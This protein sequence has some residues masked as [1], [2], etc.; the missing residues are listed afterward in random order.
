VLFVA[1]AAT[2][3][4]VSRPLVLAQALDRDEYDVHFACTPAYHGLLADSSFTTWPLQSL[5]G[6]EF[7]RALA[8]GRRLF[9]LATLRRYV[10][11]DLKLIQAVQ[12]D[13]IV[14]D[15]RF[16][17][18]VS[19]ARQGVPH[20]MIANAYWSPFARQSFHVP[21]L[22]LT[23]VLGPR[24]GEAMFKL[25]RPLV[26]AHHNRPINQL[27]KEFGLPTLGWDHRRLYTDA[28]Q[29]LYADVPE[30]VPTYDLPEHHHYLG[31]ITWSFPTPLPDWWDTLAADRPL[32][33]VCLGSSGRIELLP[34]V[35]EALG[36]LPVTVMASTC[37]RAR[38]A[39]LPRNVHWAEYL[40]GEAASARA[41]LV[42][43]HGG[44]AAAYVALAAGKPV[45]GIPSNIDQHLTIDYIERA[46]AGRSV[47]AEWATSER[48]RAVVAAMLNDASL[49]AAAAHLGKVFASCD[50]PSRFR[51]LLG[52][53]LPAKPDPILSA[54]L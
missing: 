54:A 44:S 15:L 31:P 27:R 19:A 49:H 7:L 29:V 52:R 2:L 42:I 18:S 43:C 6:H 26:F 11:E 41:D 8:N 53:M 48:V 3:C 35:L 28:Q 36:N 20:W 23:R 45:L 39:S 46:G 47:R 5:P 34:N 16:S 14:S 1:E 21:E 17:L 9:E 40:P 30:L 50:A 12:P 33:Y 13:L 51:A 4:H 25:L 10:L 37:G 32:V 24:L 38:P 22:P